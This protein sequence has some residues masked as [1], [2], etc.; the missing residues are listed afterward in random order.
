MDT[1]T[2]K[3][4]QITIQTKN[5][6]FGGNPAG[7]PTAPLMPEVNLLVKSHTALSTGVL[8]SGIRSLPS[9]PQGRFSRFKHVSPG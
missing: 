4:N 2:K 3:H 5:N 9:Y 8:L 7:S 1:E 6:I